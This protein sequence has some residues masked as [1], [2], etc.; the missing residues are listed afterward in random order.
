VESSSPESVED[1]M[2][3]MVLILTNIEDDVRGGTISDE[4]VRYL[5]RRHFPPSLWR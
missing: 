3:A 4:T 2:P 1:P 5:V